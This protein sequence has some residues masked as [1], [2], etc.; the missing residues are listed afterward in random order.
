MDRMNIDLWVGVFV[1]LGIAA[2][3]GLAIKAGNLTSNKLGD[4]YS[5]SAKFENIGGLKPRAPVKSAGVVVGRVRG[6]SF[7]TKFYKA[8]VKL[9]I[10][11]RYRFPKDS[12]A[13]IFTS[14]LLGEQYVG[15]EAGGDDENLNNGDQF[16]HTQD[17]VVL[18]KLISQLLFNKASEGKSNKSEKS[19]LPPSDAVKTESGKPK[20]KLPLGFGE[21]L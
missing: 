18:E 4:T 5:V 6:I 21:A 20:P 3:L 10:D 7:D 9:D 8:L 11:E 1:A 14:G 17:A 2:L 19:E 13:S 15:I 16:S 12:F